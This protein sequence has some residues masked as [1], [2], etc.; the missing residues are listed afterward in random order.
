MTRAG[1]LPCAPARP[2]GNAIE[3]IRPED[4][5]E[6]LVALEQGRAKT[7]LVTAVLVMRGVVRE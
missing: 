1:S 2:F 5:S 6:A 4:V 7:R 3:A